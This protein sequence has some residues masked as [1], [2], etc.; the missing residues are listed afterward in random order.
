MFQI[1]LF[2]LWVD[3]GVV[4]DVVMGHSVGEIAAM[5][6]SGAFDQEKAIR[7]AIA[8]SNALSRLGEVPG[9]MAAIGMSREQA[10][11]LIDGI[12]RDRGLDTGLW[13][14]ASN[15]TNAV[16]VSGRNEL[17]DAVVESCEKAN[18][19]ARV[20]KVG[21][22][23]HSPMVSP[24]QEGFL[25]EVY[26]LVDSTVNVPTRGFIS[27]VEGRLFE[28]GRPLDAQYCWHLSLIHI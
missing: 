20:L 8:R 4:P 19:F 16:S 17:V 25:S 1:A 7:T 2:D 13:V 10:Q 3:L 12:L 18:I 26:P 27:T 24:C 5:Y 23:Y 28:P 14:S 6:A 9:G 21:G 15:S 22:P 11:M